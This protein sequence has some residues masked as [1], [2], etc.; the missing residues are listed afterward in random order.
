MCRLNKLEVFQANLSTMVVF[1]TFKKGFNLLTLLSIFTLL[2]MISG[3]QGSQD[4]LREYVNK[5]HNTT[6]TPNHE[7]YK[8]LGCINFD[9]EKSNKIVIGQFFIIIEDDDR[10][11]LTNKEYSR[12][13]NNLDRKSNQTHLI[14]K[15]APSS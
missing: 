2:F 11:K 10:I 15:K 12:S 14:D 7:Q 9:E 13:S 8:K 6:N 3:T 5:S 1:C 4:N